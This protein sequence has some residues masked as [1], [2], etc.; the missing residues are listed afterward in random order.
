VR[1]F[2]LDKHY[3]KTEVHAKRA[4]AAFEVETRN[5]SNLVLNLKEPTSRKVSIQIDG[6]KLDAAAANDP[7][8]S[9]VVLLKNN[10]R[11]ETV[12][13]KDW[14]ALLDKSP[15]KAPHLQGP[16]DDAFADA[17]LCVRGTGKPWHDAVKQYVDGD[18]ARF[19]AEWAKFMRGRVPVKSDTDVTQDDILSRHLILFGD[20]GSNS[21]LRKILKD[22]PLTWNNKEI[23]FAGQTVP[24]DM[25]LP[26]LIQRNPLNPSR[27]IVLNSGHTFHAKEFQGTNALLFPRLG[28]YALLK[29][30]PSE[31]NPLNVEVVRAGLFDERWR[32]PASR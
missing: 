4:P 27:Y 1:I 8:T 9:F 21:L 19:Q 23:A 28:D 11:W 24:S 6:Q 26:V 14:I 32:M 7:P 13:P 3:E 30:A 15:G 10:D 22:L 29:L 17:F 25:H 12:T 18:L 20:P 5:V 2:G 31:S 16:I